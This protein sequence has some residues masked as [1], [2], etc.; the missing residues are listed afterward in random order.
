MGFG[1]GQQTPYD[2]TSPL[3]EVTFIIRQMLARLNTMKV[4]QV[5]AVHNTGGVSTA[6]TVD[7]QPL[8]SQIDGNGNA[9]PH[10]TVFGLQYFRVQGGVNA[11]ICDPAV[12]DI[13]YVV[14]S[15]RDITNINTGQNKPVTPGCFRRNDLADG[16][17]VGGILNAKPKQYIQF[18]DSTGI[19]LSDANGNQ[20]VMGKSGITFVGPVIMQNAVT[21]QN[22]VTLQSTLAV[23]GD[24][25]AS[26]NLQLAGSIKTIGGGT[27]TANIQ[28]VGA[29]QA[30]FGGAD[31]VGLQSHEHIYV[32]GTGAPTNSN[33]PIAG[34]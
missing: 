28:T 22:T 13:G 18:V 8:V 19:T 3:G 32:P 7:V 9:Q 29:I 30:G 23:T 25:A 6:G 31:Q 4:V 21:M 26:G 12:G 1:Y 15:D 24:L 17:Y 27:Y 2:T 33:P 10:G 34:T 16:I 20:I 14:V 11:V 5:K